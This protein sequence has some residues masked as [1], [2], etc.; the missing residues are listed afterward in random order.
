MNRRT[1]LKVRLFAVS[2]FLFTSMAARSNSG[3]PTAS[4]DTSLAKMG[5][6]IYEQ[7]IGI[8]GRPIMATL[9]SIA[10]QSAPVTIPASVLPCIGCHGHDGLGRSE[11]GLVPSDIRWSTLERPGRD[12]GHGRQR[13]GYTKQAFVRAVSMGFDSNN[14]RLNLAMPRYQLQHL[15]TKALM[16]WLSALQQR[17]IPGVESTHITLGLVVENETD[18]RAGLVHYWAKAITNAGGIHNR[19]IRIK[20]LSRQ[21]SINELSTVFAA[22]FLDNELADNFEESPSEESPSTPKIELFH[23]IT[24]SEASLQTRR[25]W[26]HLR[27]RRDLDEISSSTSLFI[28]ERLN[29]ITEALENLGRK[30]D[31]QTFTPMINAESS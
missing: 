7:G 12:A 13:P 31:Q 19:A 28:L 1:G 9:E 24:E 22:L 3:P 15:E 27:H 30:P 25:R 5:Q 4:V 6:R 8:N 2:L 17:K 11:G 20:V 14:R 16:A 29:D 23:E 10:P 26:A 21:A 18:P